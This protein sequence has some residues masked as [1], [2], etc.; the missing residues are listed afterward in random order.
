MVKTCIGA[1]FFGQESLGIKQVRGNGVLMLTSEELIFEYWVPK[2]VL[3]I[4]LS[5]IH[6]IEQTKWHLRKTKGVN[7]VKVLFTNKN[8]IE[9]S[10]AWWVRETEEWLQL[11]GNIVNN[12]KTRI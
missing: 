2:K 3:R 6:S 1:N 12:R 10:A 11:L 5:K 8:F 7:L 4:P 9:D